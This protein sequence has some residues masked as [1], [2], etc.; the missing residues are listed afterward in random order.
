MLFNMKRNDLS[1]TKKGFTLVEMIVVVG[2]ISI[3]TATIIIGSSS[4]LPGIRLSGST[5]VLTSKLREAQ[6]RTITEQNRHLI[7]FLPGE[8]RLI[9]LEDASEEVI[10]V[11]TI[12]QI[13]VALD[14]PTNE[15]IFAPDGGPSV[16]GNITLSLDGNSK[17]INVSPA[18]FIKIQ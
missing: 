4:Y 18:G 2:I 13:A 14:M 9:R 12:P 10:S 17:I 5:R 8:Y 16:N 6:E 3:V 7:R 11:I 15:I 1:I